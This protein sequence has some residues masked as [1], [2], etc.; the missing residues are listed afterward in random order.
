MWAELSRTG[1]TFA[2]DTSKKMISN[3]GYILTVPSNRM[4]ELGY[5]LAF[6]NS[7]IMLYQLD[8][9]TTRF[10]DNGWRWLR[11]FVEDLR[12]PKINHNDIS[13]IALHT[14]KSNDKENSERINSV[15]A[16]LFDFNDQEISFINK[17]LNGY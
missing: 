10:D 17:T 13:K 15:I 6:M 11:Q 4:Q 16:S 3:S 1:N 12:I 7:R 2:I 14:S 5:I 9:I 8:R